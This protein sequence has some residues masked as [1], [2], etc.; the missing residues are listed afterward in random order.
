MMYLH[1]PFYMYEGVPVVPD[2]SDPRQFYYFPNRPHLAV[3]EHNRPAIRF[4]VYKENLDEI[5]PEEEQ[6]TG[7]L[8]FDTSL[9]WPEETLKKVAKKIQDDLDLDDLPRLAPLLYKSGTVRLV[10]LDRSTTL[11]GDQPKPDDQPANA[12]A[13]PPK[14]E[15]V[16][17]LESSGMPSL[18][19]ENRAIF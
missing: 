2:Y 9:A 11:P 5:T 6:A 18:Y 3:D 7:F 14:E 8:F 12:D 15:W 19:G 1:P 13:P 17:F 16:T 4:L 10:F